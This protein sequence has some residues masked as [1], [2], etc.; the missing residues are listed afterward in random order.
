[1]VY[2]QTFKLPILRLVL[3]NLTVVQ[4]GRNTLE[5][6]L[7]RFHRPKTCAQSWFQFQDFLKTRSA[8][9]RQHKTSTTLITAHC[10]EFRSLPWN[11]IGAVPTRQTIIWAVSARRPHPCPLSSQ[12]HIVLFSPLRLWQGQV[13][14][15]GY[16]SQHKN[17]H[18]GWQ[19][20]E[21]AEGGWGVFWFI[22]QTRA[23]TLRQTACY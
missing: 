18:S 21:H 14:W 9:I 8:V 7:R 3:N 22:L 19:L 5:T 13:S 11:P 16:N 6:H 4:M 12:Q 1:M 2:D 20:T 15:T 10:T 23:C 17:Y